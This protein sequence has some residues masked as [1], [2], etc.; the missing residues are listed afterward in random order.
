MIILFH[1]LSPKFPGG[2]YSWGLGEGAKARPYDRTVGRAKTLSD[3]RSQAGVT[4]QLTFS[5]VRVS[6]FTANAEQIAISFDNEV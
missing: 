3:W 6:N 4:K 5:I 1:L 2:L